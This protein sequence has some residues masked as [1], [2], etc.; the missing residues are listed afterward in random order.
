MDMISK[1]YPNEDDRNIILTHFG[2]AITGLSSKDQ[3]NLFLLG[4][5]SSGKSGFLKCIK[6]SGCLY[7]NIS[8]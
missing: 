3:T 1:T 8:I 6:A 5:G 2:S 7:E 4:R